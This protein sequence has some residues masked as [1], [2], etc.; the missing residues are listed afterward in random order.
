MWFMRLAQLLSLLI[1]II[2]A[3]RC[4]VLFDFFF[5]RPQEVDL[6]RDNDHLVF[7][8]TVVILA[9]LL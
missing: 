1:Q 4:V 6:V 5:D 3:L 7:N 9:S 8:C 2:V